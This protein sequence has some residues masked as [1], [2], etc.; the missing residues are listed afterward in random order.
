VGRNDDEVSIRTIHAALDQGINL[1]DTAPI[2]GQGR[3][4]EIV[5]EALRQTDAAKASF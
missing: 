1:I 5:G 4:E 2:Y 3:S